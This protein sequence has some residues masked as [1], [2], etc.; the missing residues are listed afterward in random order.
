VEISRS[1]EG[2]EEA[3]GE[4]IFLCIAADRWLSDGSQAV[5]A[6]NS[7]VVLRDSDP[8]HPDRV[9]YPVREF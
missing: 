4:E 6:R 2:K 5:I 1:I 7:M 9:I 8:F 3:I